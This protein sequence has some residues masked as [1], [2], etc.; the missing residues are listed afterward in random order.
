M[1]SSPV[2]HFMHWRVLTCCRGLIWGLADTIRTGI[3]GRGIPVS[4]L[5]HTYRDRGPVYYFPT[6]LTVK[7]PVGLLAL[8]LSGLILLPMPNFPPSWRLP[9]VALVLM[10]ALFLVAL[11]RGVSYG[12]VRHALPVRR[13]KRLRR[14]GFGPRAIEPL[15]SGAH[16][17]CRRSGYSR[18]LCAAAHSPMGVL[19]R[20][21]RWAGESVP[22]FRR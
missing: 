17:G 21:R 16:P 15:A 13:A 14:N 7:L 6:V 22:L 20:T 10:A 12:G 3:E 2:V 19:Q 11:A 5:G 1:A 18:S 4:F 8:A 9:C